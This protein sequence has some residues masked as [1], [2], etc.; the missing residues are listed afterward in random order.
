MTNKLK[1][2]TVVYNLHK[3]GTQRAA[4][5]FAEAYKEL[6]HD[7]RLIAVYGGGSRYDEI[8][9]KINTWMNLS[10]AT[11]SQIKKW[12]PDIIHIHSHGLTNEDVNKIIETL[13]SDNIKIIETNVFSSP[14]TWENKLDY[15]FQLSTWAT[16]LYLM[17]GG[18][19]NKTKMAPNPVNCNRFKRANIEQI[20]K[21]KNNYNIPKNAF[22]LGRVGQS[23][24][25][26]W[27]LMLMSVF[28]KL[29]R[30]DSTI[31][32]IIVNAPNNIIK[33]AK[34]SKFS[35]RII[36]I[37][38]IIGDDK[39]AIAYSSF[40]LM[41]HAAE[42]GE[43]FGYVLTESILCETPVITLNTP[44]ADNS[45]AEVVEHLR[46]GYVVNSEKGLINSILDYMKSR[47]KPTINPSSNQIV[48]RYNYKKVAQ[49][50]LNVIA[51][52]HAEKISLKTLKCKLNI[53]INNCSDK[54]SPVST[55]MVTYG[56]Y[57]LRR[58]TLH[59][60]PFRYLKAEITKRIGFQK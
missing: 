7:S 41:I 42:K 26:K 25:G 51:A 23:H 48:E 45:Q 17:R 31:Y 15:S 8:K 40:N 3:G 35:K 11:L 5:V 14:S 37:D 34:N 13:K 52:K 19:P 1:I 9:N 58:L 59:K 32:L 27:S 47:G 22:I 2:L 38:K 16:W 12:Q 24:P 20:E 49:D 43:S 44:W 4:Q 33:A 39:L 55:L 28:N 36:C 10:E 50:I 57:N 56:F 30:K 18:N 29:A 54:A 21:F 6:N 53:L 60:Y 46:G